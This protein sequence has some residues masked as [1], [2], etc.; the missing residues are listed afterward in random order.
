MQIFNFTYFDPITFHQIQH[1]RFKIHYAV[2]IN[3]DFDE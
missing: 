3:V 2:L 1:R